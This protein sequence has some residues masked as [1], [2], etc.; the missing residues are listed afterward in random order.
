MTRSSSG[1]TAPDQLEVREEQERRKAERRQAE[2]K[3]FRNMLTILYSPSILE[4]V[5]SETRF[6]AYGVLVNS[7]GARV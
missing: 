1:T 7:K 5:F 4:E 3:A 2:A 6:P